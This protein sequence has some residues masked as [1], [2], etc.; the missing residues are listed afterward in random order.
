MINHRQFIKTLGSSVATA[1]LLQPFPLPGM[2]GGETNAAKRPNIVVILADDLAWSDLAC[3]GNR[4]HETPRI[5]RLAAESLR[6]TDAYAACAV[7]APTRASL[8]TG[9]SP[10]RL[11]LTHII[12]HRN[13]GNRA[14]REPDWTP[15]LPLP[16]QTLAEIL[17]PAGYTSASIGKWHLGG[18]AGRTGAEGREGDP[19]NQGFDVNVAG[20]DLGQPPDY[21][22]PYERTVNGRDFALHPL[23]GGSK[24]E[25]LTERLTS[26][27]EQFMERNANRPFFLYMSYFTPHTS[28]GARLQARPELIEKYKGKRA[29]PDTH[30]N[31]TYAAMVEH[32]DRGVGRILDKLDQLNLEDDTIVI[33]TSDNGGFGRVTSNKPLRGAKGTPYEGGLRVP[34]IIR[35][36]GRTQPGRTCAVPAITPDLFATIADGAGIQSPHTD[37][38]D[39]VSLVP[40]IDGEDALERDAIF[41]HFPHYLRQQEP[42]SVIRAGDYKLIEFLESRRIELFNLAEDLGETADLADDMPEKAQQLR[43][44]LDQ[45]RYRVG[46]QMPTQKTAD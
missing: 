29:P 36:P 2:A 43:E 40:L 19:R 33:F 8:L 35:W 30:R 26:E 38:R 17:T 9:K 45:W 15:Y 7:C 6:F 44:R 28:I 25:Y 20:C 24:G 41:W 11:H 31:P 10:A 16:E 3:Y 14:L 27:A 18:H 37:E 13:P 12:Q 39:G 46:A 42:Y 34:L 22:Y 23:P 21:F 4:Y 1:A 5:D 32:L